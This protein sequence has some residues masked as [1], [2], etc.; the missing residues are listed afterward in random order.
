MRSDL[1]RDVFE[2]ENAG[3]NGKNF[4]EETKRLGQR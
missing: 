4:Q 1:I 3:R 2:R